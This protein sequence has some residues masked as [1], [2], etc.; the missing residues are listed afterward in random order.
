M[1]HYGPDRQTASNLPPI[2]PK[3][4]SHR[5]QIVG[6]LEDG[7]TLI[8]RCNACGAHSTLLPNGGNETVETW[9]PHADRTRWAR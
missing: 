9:G 2:C 7:K 3:C 6:R 5:T 8:V 4:G 1:V